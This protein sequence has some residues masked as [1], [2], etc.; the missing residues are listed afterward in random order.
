MVC[1][2]PAFAEFEIIFATV[3]LMQ[4]NRKSWKFLDLYYFIVLFI[5]LILK[6]S[7]VVQEMCP[8]N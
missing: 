4:E 5:A 2:G 6:L 1:S 3:C 7:L 8:K